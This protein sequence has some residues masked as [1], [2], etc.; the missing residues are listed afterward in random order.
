MN[1]T[2]YHYEMPTASQACGIA[3]PPRGQSEIELEL[4]TLHQGL[5]HLT[6]LKNEL[7]RRLA[8]ASAGSPECNEA[9]AP[10]AANFPDSD[11]ARSI[12]GAHARVVNLC[13]DISQAI[14][15]LR[16]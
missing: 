8:P 12:A 6:E 1:K 3:E 7:R 13:Q 4:N 2:I 9:A 11:I 10:R 14:G 15:L 16:C 5:E